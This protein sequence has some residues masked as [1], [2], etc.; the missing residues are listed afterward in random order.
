MNV[1]VKALCKTSAEFWARGFVPEEKFFSPSLELFLQNR[2]V[3]FFSEFLLLEMTYF[4]P[5]ISWR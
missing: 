5:R 2:F 1:F 3:E 4:D